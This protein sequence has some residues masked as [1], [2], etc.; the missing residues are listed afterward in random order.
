MLFP[1]QMTFSKGLP[2]AN[3][4][5]PSVHLTASSKVHSAWVRGFE[6][7][8]MMGLGTDLA[9]CLTMFSVKEDL[10]VERPIRQVG[11]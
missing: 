5:S 3:K 10:T 8:K 2:L 4:T 1:A 11:L 6:R 7:A 9:M